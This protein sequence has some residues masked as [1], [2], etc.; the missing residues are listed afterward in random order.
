MNRATKHRDEGL[1]LIELLVYC[2]RLVLVIG[3]VGGVLS[4]VLG[5]STT[6]RTVTAGSTAAQLVA[7][8]VATGIRNSSDFRL[9]VPSGTDQLL[10]SRKAGSDGA[11]TWGCAAWYYSAAGGGSIRY[12]YSAATIV[13][14]TA[15]EL[16]SWTLLNEGVTPV[17]GSTV[18]T[19]TGSM[20]NVSFNGTT[21][22]R[23]PVRIAS[24]ALSRAGASGSL[25]CF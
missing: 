16:A 18:F 13:A 3:A 11:L 2:A 24:S 5:A 21:P 15:A 4:S 10:V 7:D 23:P 1:T 19:A 22:G 14:P 8:S 9:T 20:L 12:K 17:T 6:V 25:T